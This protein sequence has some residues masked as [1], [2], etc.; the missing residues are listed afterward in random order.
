MNGKKL[1]RYSMQLAMLNQ[2]FV[3]KLI[4]EAEYLLIEKRLMKD[5][6]IVSNITA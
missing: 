1:L 6:G 5:Y 4:S 2:L 3:K